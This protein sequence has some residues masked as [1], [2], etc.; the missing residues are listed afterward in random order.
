MQGTTESNYKEKLQSWLFVLSTQR[1]RSLQPKYP[2]R[3]YIVISEDQPVKHCSDNRCCPGCWGPQ[4][5]PSCP[6]FLMVG[7][8]WVRLDMEKAQGPPDHNCWTVDKKTVSTESVSNHQLYLFVK[9]LTWQQATPPCAFKLCM[10]NKLI[11][12]WKHRPTLPRFPLLQPFLAHLLVAQRNQEPVSFLSSGGTSETVY[13]SWRG[14]P[15]P[16]QN[17]HLAAPASFCRRLGGLFSTQ[18]QQRTSLER[19]RNKFCY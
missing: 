17:V 2:L 14:S 19:N 12:N 7:E 4:M 18:T 9:H 13:S 6:S 5:V 8:G 16:P 1:K 3:V 15:E 11:I 10:T